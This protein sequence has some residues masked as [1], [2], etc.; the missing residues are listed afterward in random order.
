MKGVPLSVTISSSP[1][2]RHNISSNIKAPRV[3]AVSVHSKRNS[4]HADSEQR[5]CT[6]YENPWDLGMCIVST[7][8]LWKRGA[9]VATSGGMMT[10]STD[11]IW[12]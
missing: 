2:H 12:H 6:M 10:L 5:A 7:W 8:A 9:G 1:P 4:D 11:R 3:Q